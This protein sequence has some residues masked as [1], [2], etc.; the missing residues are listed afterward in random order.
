[1][2]QL[3][4]PGCLASGKVTFSDG[5]TAEWY[6]DQMGR[7]GVAPKQKSYRPAQADLAEFQRA[8]DG[9]LQKLGL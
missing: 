6:F 2:D 5:Q 4:R 8:L 9:E 3:T 7:L 1:V